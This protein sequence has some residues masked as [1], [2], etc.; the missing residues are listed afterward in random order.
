MATIDVRPAVIGTI[1]ALGMGRIYHN[2]WWDRVSRQRSPWTDW[3]Q[4]NRV[5]FIHVPKNAGTSLYETFG[6]D[7]PDNTH[8]PVTGYLAS[9][10]A[11]FHDSYSF[12]FVRNPWDRIVSAFQYLKHQPI[13]DDDKRWATQTLAPFE[14]FEDFMVAMER[15]SFRNRVVGWRHFKPQWHFLTDWSGRNAV[16]Y[17]GR[18]ETLAKDVDIIGDAIGVTPQ[19]TLKNSTERKPY[20]NYYSPQSRRLVAKIYAKD[21]TRYN[22]A[23][24]S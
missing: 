16:N 6:M 17:I 22:Y 21:I 10:A 13:S 15:R 19:L 8:C 9:D 1:E 11:R 24:Q 7:V 23:W 4:K 14:T 3:S 12:G 5:V 18:F 20:F 2:L